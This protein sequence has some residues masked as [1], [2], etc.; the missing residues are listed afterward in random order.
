MVYICMAAI[1]RY[2]KGSKKYQQYKKYTFEIR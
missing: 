1:L 2:D